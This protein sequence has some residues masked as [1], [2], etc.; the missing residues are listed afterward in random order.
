MA[1]AQKVRNVSPWE[2]IPK[3]RGVVVFLALTREDLG[4][5]FSSLSFMYPH[6]SCYFDCEHL[7][8]AGD[9]LIARSPH[10]RAG[11]SV[12]TVPTGNPV[13]LWASIC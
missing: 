2:G 7:P 10:G 8:A 11:E 1:K 4:A 9:V 13:S 12:G 3:D 5:Y 6:V